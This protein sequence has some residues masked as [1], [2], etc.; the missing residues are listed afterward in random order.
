MYN[1]MASLGMEWAALKLYS[2]LGFSIIEE[3]TFLGF[4][5]YANH[6]EYNEA[7]AR[8]MMSLVKSRYNYTYFFLQAPAETIHSRLRAQG[9]TIPNIDTDIQRYQQFLD[10]RPKLYDGLYIK[11]INADRPIDMICWDILSS[12]SER[13]MY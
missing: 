13:E 4:A 2:M 5:I 3:R 12:L 7:V 11:Q 9:E 1:P 6:L 10:R 8:E